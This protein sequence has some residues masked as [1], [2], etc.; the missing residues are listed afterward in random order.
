MLFDLMLDADVGRNHVEPSKNELLFWS[1]VAR[2]ADTEPLVYRM[3][4][5]KREEYVTPDTLFD[6]DSVASLIGVPVIDTSHPPGAIRGTRGIQK[7][8]VLQEIGKMSDD[9]G[10][11]LVAPVLVWDAALKN[12]LL[13]QKKIGTSP[14]YTR[15]VKNEGDKLYQQN[16][17]YDHLLVITDSSQQPRN[18]A[19]NTT[20]LDSTDTLVAEGL[21]LP[22]TLNSPIVDSVLMRRFIEFTPLLEKAGVEVD[23][24]WSL[25]QL[26]DAIV[27]TL[28]K[29]P[30]KIFEVIDLTA[31]N[32]KVEE[33]VFHKHFNRL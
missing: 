11:Y 6:A 9:G 21:E 19:G 3:G 13:A 29:Q 4:E 15:V 16:R 12:R 33:D 18:G 23:F 5:G 25:E 24:G 14:G 17:R 27:R 30:N 2:V 20:V 22:V 8:V 28:P 7:G 31:K 32:G 1:K 26:N 10:T